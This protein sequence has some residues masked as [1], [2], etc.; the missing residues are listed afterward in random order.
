ML[1][2]FAPVIVLAAEY[3]RIF[4]LTQ[5]SGESP[6]EFSLRLRQSASR[7][8]PLMDEAAVTNLLE[9]LDPS[10][11]GFVQSALKNQN[12]TFTSKIQ[13]ADM[14]YSSVR[15]TERR[16]VARNGGD[17]KSMRPAV[18]TNPN[19]ARETSDRTEKQ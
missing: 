14:V 16:F 2:T 6:R 3:K 4:S 13:E 18:F 15:A 5:N 17:L 1:S 19:R 9:R 12:P 7:L 11:S 10:L 8:G